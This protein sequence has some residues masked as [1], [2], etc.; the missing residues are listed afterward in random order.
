MPETWAPAE[1]ARVSG[2]ATVIV[3]PPNPLLTA[4]TTA[5]SEF[6]PRSIVKVWP[7]RKPVAL[8][9]GITVAPAS[10]AAPTLV[11]PAVPTV[12]MTAVSRFAPVSIM[13]FWPASKPATLV[14]LMLVAPA[15]AAEDTVAAACVT[16]SVQL[17]SVSA[18][19]GKRPALVL[20]A[21]AAA[22]PMLMAPPGAG[23][24]QPVCS[25]PEVV[26]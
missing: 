9:T 5:V 24:W 1:C 7:S 17:L 13:I 25:E 4:A 23:T 14:T 12:A 3:V 22:G 8:T 6:V 18:P 16:K 10:V 26:W 15:S 2:A 21:P 19:S 11:A 20:V